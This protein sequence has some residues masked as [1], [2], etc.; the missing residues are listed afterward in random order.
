M[1]ARRL[2]AATAMTTLAALAVSAP[3]QARPLGAT[4]TP[5]ACVAHRDSVN[6]GRAA[7]GG[8]RKDANEITAAQ[9]AAMESRLAAALATKGGRAAFTPVTVK[10]YMHVITDGATGNLSSSMIANQ[11]SVLN[12]AYAA[13]GFSFTLAATDY[14]NNATWYNG[15]TS[16]TTA[17]RNMKTALRKGTKAD[18]NLYSANLGGGLLG[19]ATFP[20][21]TYD[22]MDGVVLLD[23]SLPGGTAA[24][25][26]L[27]DT[28]THEAGH[29]FGLYHTFQGGCTGKGDYVDDTPAEKSAAFGCPTGRDSCARQAGKDPITNFMD[30]TDDACMTQF[31]SGQ[32]ARMQSQWVAF[33]A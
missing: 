8:N 18:L 13:T 25:Y 3:A 9:A 29:W 11:I 24:P 19:W 26:N 30:Y 2:A 10:V 20:K 12:A 1:S 22:V 32:I 31:T 23:Q 6:I 16:G 21:S 7:Q 17:E 27:G 33:R 15:L 14:T 4:D 5:S 28:A